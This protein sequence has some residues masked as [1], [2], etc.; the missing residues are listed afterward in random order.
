MVTTATNGRNCNV[1]FVYL[2]WA[3]ACAKWL[4]QWCDVAWGVSSTRPQTTTRRGGETSAVA[5]AARGREDYSREARGGALIII[6]YKT[7][8]QPYTEKS[9]ATDTH[10]A[11][12]SSRLDLSAT[13][14][15]PRI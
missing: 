8:P 5:L 11:P 9:F 15:T 7:P 3:C 4:Q 1:I 6:A 13:E 12:T 2:C 14:D 10:L